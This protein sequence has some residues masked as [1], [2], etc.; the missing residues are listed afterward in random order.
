MFNIFS[1]IIEIQEEKDEQWKRSMDFI[2]ACA[3]LNYMSQIVLMMF[4]DPAKVCILL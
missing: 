1:L 2:G 4:E 3:E